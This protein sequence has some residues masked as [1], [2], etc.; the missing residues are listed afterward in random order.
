MATNAMQPNT[1]RP[2]PLKTVSMLQH[3]AS[4]VRSSMISTSGSKGCSVQPQMDSSLGRLN[5][6]MPAMA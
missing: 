5:L 1:L 4:A 2:C 6:C 3:L